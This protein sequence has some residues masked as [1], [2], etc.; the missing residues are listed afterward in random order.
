MLLSVHLCS[1]GFANK[2]HADE[3]AMA[4]V[5]FKHPEKAIVK[6][7]EG[8]SPSSLCLGRHSEKLHTPHQRQLFGHSCLCHFILKRTLKGRKDPHSLNF[9]FFVSLKFL[10]KYTE[11]RH[12]AE[13][14]YKGLGKSMLLL[15][16]VPVMKGS[17]CL[18]GINGRHR[19]SCSSEQ[20]IPHTQI[21]I[22]SWLQ[23]SKAGLE[24]ELGTTH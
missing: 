14:F 23:A 15:G 4:T 6:G 20:H 22:F 7:W 8:K 10:C 21:H 19:N 13:L 12:Q 2:P 24:H 1:P 16:M 18:L 9:N 5:D 11:G 3:R 17:Q